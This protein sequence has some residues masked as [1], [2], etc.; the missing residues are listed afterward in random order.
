MDDD[1]LTYDRPD[2]SNK[3]TLRLSSTGMWEVCSSSQPSSANECHSPLGSR[4]K[5]R[6]PSVRGSGSNRSGR[7]KRTK[8]RSRTKGEKSS[9]DS[10]FCKADRPITPAATHPKEEHEA[11]LSTSLNSQNSGDCVNGDLS[12]KRELRPRP[13]PQKSP[14]CVSPLS[15]SRLRSGRVLANTDPDYRPSTY[16]QR[17][18]DNAK[19]VG[20]T[21]PLLT[22]QTSVQV[23]SPSPRVSPLKP[24][25]KRSRSSPCKKM[26]VST[27][28]KVKES[29]VTSPSHKPCP[30]FNEQSPRKSN[31]APTAETESDPISSNTTTTTG[32]KSQT[33][34][35]EQ[36][37]DFIGSRTRKRQ[38][39]ANLN[40]SSS[41]TVPGFLPRSISAGII[42]EHS[43]SPTNHKYPTRHKATGI[44]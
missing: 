23:Q 40:Q 9:L 28:T 32:T 43:K 18:C 35:T 36:D 14:N 37:K 8:K 29:N 15:S 30:H 12:D 34:V 13:S 24:I 17:K 41:N 27:D 7:S 3:V 11:I 38:Y 44:D 1:F 21:S 10:S 2:N 6:S 39:S 22:P 25:S 19:A 4:N 33:L 31:I 42:T 26:T 16:N 20:K 5:S